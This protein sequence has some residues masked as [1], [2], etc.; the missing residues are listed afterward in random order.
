MEYRLYLLPRPPKIRASN[1]LKST[2]VIHQITVIKIGS[3]LCGLTPKVFWLIFSFVSKIRLFCKRHLNIFLGF[4]RVP[5]KIAV[6]IIFTMAHW[7]PLQP[8]WTLCYASYCTG[9][10]FGWFCNFLLFMSAHVLVSA[11]NQPK[12]TLHGNCHSKASRR[13][14]KVPNVSL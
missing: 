7:E 12:I 13:A 11:Q 8:F 2:H 14:T 10:I 3:S 4:Y 9:L 6:P 1:T 5:A